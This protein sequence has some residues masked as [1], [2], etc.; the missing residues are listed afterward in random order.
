MPSA[1]AEITR[2]ELNDIIDRL[3]DDESVRVRIACEPTRQN[4]IL[5]WVCYTP[6]P[7]MMV[8]H[9]LYVREKMRRRGVAGQLM[10]EAYQFG[11]GKLVYTMR[12]PDAAWLI[13]K[14]RE[15]V[16]MDVKEFLS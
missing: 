2:S 5:G 1:S 3:L 14:N 4:M 15:A 9:Y 16:M 8:L 11:Q 10:R 6:T 13:A 12:G 7:K